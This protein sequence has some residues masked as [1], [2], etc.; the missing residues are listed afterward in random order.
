M[1]Q[2]TTDMIEKAISMAG[3]T[4]WIGFCTGL[5][6]LF[7]CQWVWQSM[8]RPVVDYHLDQGVFWLGGIIFAMMIGGIVGAISGGHQDHLSRK[9][10]L[11]YAL[12]GAIGSG[13]SSTVSAFCGLILLAVGQS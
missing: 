5:V 10:R 6:G 11:G 12:G 7:A 2:S 1:A 13:L 3:L 4:A 9:A 8:I